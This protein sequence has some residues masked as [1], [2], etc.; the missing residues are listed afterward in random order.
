[1]RASPTR[2]L[3]EV[4]CLRGVAIVMMVILH[5]LWDLYYFGVTDIDPFSGFWLW[6]QRAT[7]SLFLLVV[8]VSVYL[9]VSR[10]RLVLKSET[11]VWLRQVRRGLIVFGCGLLVTLMTWLFIRE[12]VVVFGILH[13]IGVSIMLAYPFLRLGAWNLALGLAMVAAGAWLQPRSVDFPWLVWLG[14]KPDGFYTVDY[15]PMLPW[16]GVVLIG[17]FIGGVAYD[18]TGR[19]FN[20]PDLSPAPPVRLLRFLGRHSLL[21]YL[22]HQP[23]LI[24]LLILLGVVDARMLM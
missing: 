19:R 3:W 22:V 1:M 2:R 21:I 10:S 5:L 8:G 14:L 17:L 4:D 23:A 24:A 11:A 15:F 9:S 20:L 12:G 7:A 6:F 13:L 16:F 18:G